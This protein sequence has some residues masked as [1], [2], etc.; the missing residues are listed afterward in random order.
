MS[1]ITKDDWLRALNEANE[2]VADDPEAITIGEFAQMFGLRFHVASYRLRNML[3]KGRA[4]RT[5]KRGYDGAGRY[6]TLTAYK[7]TEQPKKPKRKTA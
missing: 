4:V 3:L 1:G 2:S 5:S 7:L 6:K